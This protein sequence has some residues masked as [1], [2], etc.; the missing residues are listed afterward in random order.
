MKW[1]LLFL[2][3]FSLRAE[4]PSSLIS[5]GNVNSVLFQ[6]MKTY[7]F[8]LLN[9]SQLFQITDNCRLYNYFHQTNDSRRLIRFCLN[10]KTSEGK[11]EQ[12]LLVNISGVTGGNF[13]FVQHGEDLTPITMD[14]FINFQIPTT[15]RG[16]KTEFYFDQF[17]YSLVIDRRRFP[18]KLDSSLQIETFKINIYE[19]KRSNLHYRK[20]LL[21]CDDCEGTSWLTVQNDGKNTRYYDGNQVGEVTPAHFNQMIAGWIIGPFTRLGN[22]L[23]ENLI[24]QYNW[25]AI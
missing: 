19:D 25:P 10:T 2:L 16:M 23:K 17:T 1:L 18:E 8:Q 5:Q 22:N 14:K 12:E 13:R 9:R 3:S 4:L 6:P 20:Y 11:I 7:M 15:K 21:S 24:S